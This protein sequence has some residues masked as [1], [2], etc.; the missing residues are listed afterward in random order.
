M[1]NDTIEILIASPTI[2][3]KMLRDGNLIAG[4]LYYKFK[5]LIFFKI[6][7]FQKIIILG[8][9]QSPAPAYGP[10]RTKYGPGP[11]KTRPRPNNFF[12][13]K[14]T[15][16]QPRSGPGRRKEHNTAQNNEKNFFNHF[17]MYSN[18]HLCINVY[19]LT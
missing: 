8:C 11:N 3:E 4:M 1:E 12:G 13:K 7:L 19:M 15:K 6:I 2:S 10:A 14:V 18:I 5:Y 16:I 17:K 9:G